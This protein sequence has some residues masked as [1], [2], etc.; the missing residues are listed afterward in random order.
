MKEPHLLRVTEGPESFAPIFDAAAALGL[1]VGW[2]DF[3]G[4]AVPAP[5]ALT[6]AAALG[7]RRAV[8]VGEGGSVTVKPRR[9]APVLKDLLREHFLGCALVLVAGEGPL[10]REIP[11]LSGA[12]DEWWIESGGE[13]RRLTAEALADALRSPKAF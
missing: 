11:S 12:G 8:A 5:H 10:C 6:A 9:G 4:E 7:A 13:T 3:P 2:L 1:H